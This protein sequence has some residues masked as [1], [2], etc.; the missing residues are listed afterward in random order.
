MEKYYLKN[1]LRKELEIKFGCTRQTVYNA[2]NGY[3]NSQL[4]KEIRRYAEDEL[5]AKK[6][7]VKA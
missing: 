4:A 6:I 3:N 2:L 7:R 5:G 1:G